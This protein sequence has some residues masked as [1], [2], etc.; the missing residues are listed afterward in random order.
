MEKFGHIPD[1]HRRVFAAMLGNLDD[2]VGAVLGKLHDEGLD[3]VAL[4]VLRMEGHDIDLTYWQQVVDR[5]EISSTP[6]R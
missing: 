3:T 2:G 6:V 5:V 4:E 1:L